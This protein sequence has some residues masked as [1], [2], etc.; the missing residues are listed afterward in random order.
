MKKFVVA[1]LIASS[2]AIQINKEKKPKDKT[3]FSRYVSKDSEVTLQNF[4]AA[5]S[6][7]TDKEK[8]YAYYM[9]KASWAGSK[10]VMHQICYEGPPIFLILQSYFQGKNFDELKKAAMKENISEAEWKMFLAYTSAFYTNMG[11]YNSF[12]SK[13][14]IPELS[15]PKFWAVLRS[16]PLAK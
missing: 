10:M 16:N 12:G 2:S 9:S 7:L 13:K 1:L 11:P 3:D 8:N 5:Y 4:T 15:R 6:Q 14:F